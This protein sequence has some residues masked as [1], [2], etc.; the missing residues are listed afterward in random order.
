MVTPLAACLSEC[1]SE[2]APIKAFNQILV[3]RGESGIKPLPQSIG[4][5]SC[6]IERHALAVLRLSYW[7]AVVA[8]SVLK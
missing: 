2:N 7:A 3:R 4:Q 1:L 6:F 5:S 8:E